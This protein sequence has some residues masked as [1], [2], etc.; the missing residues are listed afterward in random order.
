MKLLNTKYCDN[1]FGRSHASCGRTDI[2][3]RRVA[4]VPNHASI[5]SKV[6]ISRRLPVEDFEGNKASAGVMNSK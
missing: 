2:T 4:N 3:G 6:V 1:P 5:F